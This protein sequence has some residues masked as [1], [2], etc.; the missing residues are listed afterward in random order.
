[1]MACSSWKGRQ[2]SPGELERVATSMNNNGYGVIRE[3]FSEQEIDEVARFVVAES[4][5]HRGEFFF[6]NGSQAVA[7]TLLAELG[8]S[9]VFRRILAGIYEQA[10]GKSAPAGEVYQAL[11]VLS[12][13]SGLKK[14][15]KFHYDS[16]VITA[17]VP[18]IIPSA[19]GVSRGDLVIYPRLR[20]MRRNAMVNVL[21][22]VVFQNRIAQH[23]MASTSIRLL[24]RARVVRM[25]TRNIYFIRGYESL[26]A[27]EPCPPDVLRCTALFHFADPHEGCTIAKLIKNHRQRRRTFAPVARHHSSRAGPPSR[28]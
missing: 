16:Y 19:P 10:V 12:G 28:T 6:Y 18:I 4:V 11:R 5:K 3:Y 7:G 25:E 21:E 8:E 1:V 2:L 14:A 26:H 22:R 20:R 17:L 23:I 13:Q 27:N 24:L 9:P 15:W